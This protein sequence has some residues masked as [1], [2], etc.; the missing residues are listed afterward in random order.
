MKWLEIIN[1]CI[2]KSDDLFFLIVFLLHAAFQEWI[3]N[4]DTEEKT[5]TRVDLTKEQT[6][7]EVVQS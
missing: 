1:D 4:Q 3:K 7:G 2:K 5:L 6:N